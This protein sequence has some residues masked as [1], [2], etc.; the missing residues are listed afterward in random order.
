MERR[1]TAAF[2]SYS[3]RCWEHLLAV[4]TDAPSSLSPCKKRPASFKTVPFKFA[5][6]LFVFT[7]SR[8]LYH[9]IL[10]INI[11]VYNN[12]FTIR[13]EPSAM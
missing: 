4:Y 7:P 11:N 1:K 12:S 2:L 13:L 5:E 3:V 6:F 8:I 10:K 9:K